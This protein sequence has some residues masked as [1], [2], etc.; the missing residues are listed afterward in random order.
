MTQQLIQLMARNH[1][2]ALTAELTN[3]GFHVT[4]ARLASGGIRVLIRTNTNDEA[5]ITRIANQVAPGHTR[6][7]N[8]TPTQTLKG[9]RGP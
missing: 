6:G 8:A 7:P 1:E 4:P 2:T 5:T 9:Y 3:A